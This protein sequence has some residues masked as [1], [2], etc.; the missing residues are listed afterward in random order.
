MNKCEL[1]ATKGW[2]MA[3]IVV[4]GVGVKLETGNREEE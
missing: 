2:K 3:F 4:G 1:E